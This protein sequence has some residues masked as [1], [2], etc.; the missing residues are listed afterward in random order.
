VGVD[1]VGTA[2]G[3][4]GPAGARRWGAAT[5]TAGAA[6]SVA[7]RRAA[8]SGIAAVGCPRATPRRPRNR[9]AA[10][11]ATTS[12]SASTTVLATPARGAGTGWRLSPRGSA[13]WR[14]PYAGA[15]DR[16]AS[17]STPAWRAGAGWGRS[18]DGAG[19]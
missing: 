4:C 7:R 8:E 14:C 9:G 16:S 6:G 3:E 13:A 19:I 15:G 17:A 1:D 11:G 5:P 2:R 10:T 12:S 18:D